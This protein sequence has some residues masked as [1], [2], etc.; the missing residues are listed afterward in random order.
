[1]HT[2]KRFGSKIE[3]KEEVDAGKKVEF[4]D[5]NLPYGQKLKK[6]GKVYIIG[7]GDDQK[8]HCVCMAHNGTIIRV[9]D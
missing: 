6:N 1:M 8:W 7:E 4:F 3:F 2:V 5:P 9:Y